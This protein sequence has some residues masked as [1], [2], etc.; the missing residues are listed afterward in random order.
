MLNYIDDLKIV[1]SFHKTSKLYGKV[2]NR[3]THGFIFRTKGAAEYFFDN[4]KLTVDESEFIFL[5]KGMKYEYR[6]VSNEANFYT[7][8]NFEASFV[9]PSVEVYPIANFH[10]ANYV[11]ES[12]SELFKFGTQSDKCK[13]LSILYDLISYI[14]R[15]DTL[16]AEEK[17]KHTLIE[18]AI[19][20]LKR[21]IYE[22]SL[23]IEKLHNIC[24][25]SDTYFRKIFKSR[26]N[27]SPQEYILYE[28]I[29]HAKTI[30]E[31]GD[32]E[33]IKEVAL[34]VGYSDALYFSK[35][36]KKFYGFPPSYI[37]Y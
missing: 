30:L 22:S 3:L 13:C 17:N 19:E 33:S 16:K 14:L 7:S 5:P 24:G 11:T 15:L 37:S 35:A 29:T 2:E 18:P 8:I 9:N 27:M 26:F 31:S 12:F 23:K 4:K 32:F 36:F 20:Y 1:S 25:V 28:R 34:S 10:G 6:T 21:N